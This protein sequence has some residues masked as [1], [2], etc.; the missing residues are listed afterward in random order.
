MLYADR[1]SFKF[2][3]NEKL[4]H[5]SMYKAS[6]HGIANPIVQQAEAFIATDYLAA[7]SGK[8]SVLN[9]DAGIS[10]VL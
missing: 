3:F 8:L 4:D 7:S 10:A 9:G 5:G 2:H 6:V 1:K